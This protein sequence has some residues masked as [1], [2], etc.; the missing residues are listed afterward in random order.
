MQ[1]C[2]SLLRLSAFTCSVRFHPKISLT[3]LLPESTENEQPSINTQTE[4]DHH[5]NDT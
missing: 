4:E 3:I 2:I 5:A 1:L